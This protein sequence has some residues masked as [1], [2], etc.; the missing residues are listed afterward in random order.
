MDSA[1]HVFS[2]SAV[3]PGH[4]F[5]QQVQAFGGD[6]LSP[7]FLLSHIDE[8]WLSLRMVTLSE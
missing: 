8:G 6:F 4:P 3:T 7:R 2:E 5:H 1:N